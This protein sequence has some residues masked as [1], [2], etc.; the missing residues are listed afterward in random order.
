MKFK[1][2]PKQPDRENILPLINVVFLLLLFFMMTAKIKVQD[3]FVI[4]PPQ[5]EKQGEK[6]N[7]TD[8]M[9]YLSSSGE[10]AYRGEIVTADRLMALLDSSHV[11]QSA[12]P[13]VIKAD[14]Q[15]AMPPLMAL[16]DRLK[17]A[18][19]TAIELLVVAD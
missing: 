9:L 6:T 13:L 8:H 14:A 5:S 12:K 2:P 1:K 10:L 17:Q 19:V 15:L 3:P 11:G 7:S 18:D 16:L 4:T